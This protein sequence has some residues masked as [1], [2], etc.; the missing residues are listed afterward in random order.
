M[1]RLL[2]EVLGDAELAAS[3]RRAGLETIAARHTCAHR[4]DEL[5]EIGRAL[6]TPQEAVT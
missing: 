1:T 2:R 5:L 3:L 6:G 4:V